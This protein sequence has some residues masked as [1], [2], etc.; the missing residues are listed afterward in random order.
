MENGYNYV[1]IGYELW[2][3]GYPLRR[4]G[5]SG[6]LEA[7]DLYLQMFDEGIIADVDGFLKWLLAHRPTMVYNQVEEDEKYRREN[8]PLIRKYFAEHFEGKPWEQ[9]EPERWS[10]YS[11]WHKDVFGYRPHAIVCGVYVNPH[12]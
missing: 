10:F 12:R 7:Y 5:P 4:S 11:D 9:I 3:R 8:E 1:D 6:Q 2:K